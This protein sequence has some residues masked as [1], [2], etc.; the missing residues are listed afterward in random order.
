MEVENQQELCQTLGRE[1][2]GRQGSV[3]SAHHR[4]TGMGVEQM[5][6]TKMANSLSKRLVDQ[7]CRSGGFALQRKQCGGSLNVVLLQDQVSSGTILLPP[8]RQT[9][10]CQNDVRWR[11]QNNTDYFSRKD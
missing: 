11:P 3:M 9:K 4:L 5:C 10:C 6:P 1:G 2:V 7:S 8:G